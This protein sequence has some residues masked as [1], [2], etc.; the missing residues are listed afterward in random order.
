[1]KLNAYIL[2]NPLITHL[3]N[4]Q[5]LIYIQLSAEL[6]ILMSSDG[7]NLFAQ[8]LQW[9]AQTRASSCWLYSRH[10]QCT[11]LCVRCCSEVPPN[12]HRNDFLTTLS[13]SVQAHGLVLK[14]RHSPH[15]HTSY[16]VSILDSE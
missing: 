10:A 9:G 13:P 7:A 5:T 1:M 11:L 16:T 8:C 12:T 6:L 15:F 4:V 3:A 14:V 2:C